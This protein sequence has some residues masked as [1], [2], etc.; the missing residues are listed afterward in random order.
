ME[1]LVSFVRSLGRYGTGQQA[2][3]TWTGWV[4][5]KH[6]TGTRK[7]SSHLL[8]PGSL[9]SKPQSP[10]AGMQP[11]SCLFKAGQGRGFKAAPGRGAG[12]QDLRGG[13]DTRKSLEP[14]PIMEILPGM[15]GWSLA[16]CGREKRD[17][18]HVVRLYL[19]HQAW[20]H[21]SPAWTPS[22]SSAG[23]GGA[24][25]MLHHGHYQVSQVMC[26]SGMHP[27]KCFFTDQRPWNPPSEST[28]LE[29]SPHVP[30]TTK[31]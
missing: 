13:G 22:A 7:A 14:L 11:H 6:R 27:L 2:T 1:I 23:Q 4:Q 16:G 31:A 30:T 17:G 18:W 19:K 15:A 24:W 5:S 26:V 10:I 21:I 29:R 9:S 28:V 20:R 8:A 12:G 3:H 25:K